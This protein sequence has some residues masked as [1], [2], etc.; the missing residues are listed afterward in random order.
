ML[1]DKT[2]LAARR[3]AELVPHGDELI[4]QHDAFWRRTPT[5]SAEW[6]PNG[7]K[8]I[9]HMPTLMHGWQLWEGGR[10][11]EHS[12]SLLVDG[13][14]SPPVSAAKRR[15]QRCATL[16]LSE[17][18]SGR[19]YTF[20]AANNQNLDALYELSGI[21]GS[22]LRFIPDTPEL[23]L[24][25]LGL[26]QA[27]TALF[28]H[29]DLNLA[30]PKFTFVGWINPNGSSKVHSTRIQVER[31]GLLRC[32]CCG[33][34]C[35]LHHTGIDVFERKEDVEYVTK[36]EV[37][38]L[39]DRDIGN[40]NLDPDEEGL[41]PGNHLIVSHIKNQG[42]GNPSGRRRGLVIHFYCEQCGD[43]IELTLAQNKGSSYLE[44]RLPVGRGA[45]CSK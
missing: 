21:Y 23:P 45:W 20:T 15:M 43:G 34:Q 35:G 39:L 8:F 26:Q 3:K 1:P 6:V 11:V 17:V 29:G 4:F 41:F 5:G 9:A 31:D 38:S 16:Q 10:L 18:K 25:E 32:P 2:L 24:V 13:Y 28:I 7:T 40:P 36:T 19:R 22:R 27:S 12:M 44:W 30:S 14:K 37:R 33:E 42:S